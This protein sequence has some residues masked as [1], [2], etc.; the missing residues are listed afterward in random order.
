MMKAP[1]IAFAGILAVTGCA[2]GPRTV[3]EPKPVRA[4]GAWSRDGDVLRFRKAKAERAAAY[5]LEFE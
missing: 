3:D 1:G 2:L 4:F 5:L